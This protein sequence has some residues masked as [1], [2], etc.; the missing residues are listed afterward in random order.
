MNGCIFKRDDGVPFAINLGSDFCAE[1]EWGISKLRRLLGCSDTDDGLARYKT[2]R[3]RGGLSSFLGTRTIKGIFYLGFVDDPTF[4]FSAKPCTREL[5]ICGD[6]KWAGAWSDDEFGLAVDKKADPEA[7]AFIKDLQRAI[8]DS[9]IAIW[10]G[11]S[12]ARTPF[13]RAGLV[14]GITSR[15]PLEIDE[16]M[17]KAHAEDRVL[18][19]AD[20]ATGIKALLKDTGKSFFVCSP[21]WV[22]EDDKSR[23]KHPIIYWLNT[24]GPYGWYTVEE[25]TDWA[26]NVPENKVDA[27]YES[28]KQRLNR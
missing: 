6:Q 17:V 19:A 12:E 3:A 23:T 11:G 26:N 2:T 10:F 9:D 16:A 14:I 1:H 25:L 4:A 27:E 18:L 20:A 22:G 24:G 15:V 8:D 21:R 5:F 7:F 13:G 28:S